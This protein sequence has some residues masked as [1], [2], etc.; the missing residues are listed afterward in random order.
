ME[1]QKII[2]TIKRVMPAVVSIVISKHLAD[3]QKDMH[4]QMYPLLPK[5]GHGRKN[6]TGSVDGIVP[7]SDASQAQDVPAEYVD[8]DG[9]V[10]VGGSSGF[11][12]D[13][14]GL[15]LTN[16]H[17][18]ADPQAQYTVITTDGKKHPATI[19][20]RDPI[21][22]VAILKIE[23]NGLPVLPLGDA[24]KLQLGQTVIAIG[25]AL[26]IF[27]NTVSVGIVS[28]LSRAISAQGDEGAPSQEMRGL[29]QTDA[30]INPGNSGG[31][32]VDGNG[33]VIGINAAVIFGAQSIGFAIP[34]HAAARDLADL[35]KYGHVRRPYLGVRYVMIDENLQNRMQLPS[36]RGALV[37]K[38]GPNDHGVTP[39]S[40]AEAAGILENDIILECNSLPVSSEN[41]IQDVLED[42]SV[43]D[44][45]NLTVLRGGEQLPVSVTLAERK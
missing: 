38:E 2:A 37:C 13:A 35:R 27:K 11:I 45:L 40:P 30:A 39:G 33:A 1:E 32:L 44:V 42:M 29:I 24:T 7:G 12:V 23:A 21:N 25:N 9:M 4:A 26:G 41:T 28:G 20:T 36:D 34:V 17:V 5:H 8:K 18:I 31:P 14:S 6:G 15:V 19:L 16:K 22:D 43:G 3:V 10:Q